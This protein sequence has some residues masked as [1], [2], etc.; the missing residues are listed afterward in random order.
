MTD[1]HERLRIV[2]AER[3]RDELTKL[4]CGQRARRAIELLVDTDVAAVVLPE[5]PRLRMARDP[6]HRHKDVYEHTL[7]VLEQAIA[8]EPA[9][10]DLTLRWAALLHDIGKPATRAVALDGTVSFHHHELRGATMARARL[11]AL[12]Y[13]KDLVEDVSKL[14]ELHLRFH[15]YLSGWTDAAVRRY[16][17]D[18][19]SQLE[20]LHLL[21]RSDCTTRNRRKAATLAAAYDTLEGRIAELRQ[22]EE[23]DRIR[24]DLDGDEVMRILGIG[25][26][27]LVGEALRH[28]L[29]LRMEHGPLGYERAVGEL[30]RWVADR[31]G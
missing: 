20:R 30:Q 22:Q 7:I 2:S 21:V 13:P 18:A 11:S 5:L 31:P 1:M 17:R 14:V 8:L 15:G 19:G 6:V 16:V 27:P 29:A 9:G 28:L 10:P 4:L 25:P 12:R 24:P 23:L 3:T 26:G